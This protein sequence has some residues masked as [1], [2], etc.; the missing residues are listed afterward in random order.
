VPVGDGAN[1]THVLLQIT[2]LAKGLAT[3]ASSQESNWMDVTHVALPILAHSQA[4]NHANG[5]WWTSTFQWMQNL[6][7]A[8]GFIVVALTLDMIFNLFDKIL[9]VRGILDLFKR[10]KP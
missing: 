5:N 4:I 1:T 8:S 10:N 6:I 3:A 7:F 2:L 9:T